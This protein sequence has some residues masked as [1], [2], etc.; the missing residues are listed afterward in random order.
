M[1]DAKVDS[2][3]QILTKWEFRKVNETLRIYIWCL[4]CQRLNKEMSLHV[5]SFQTFF[6]LSNSSQTSLG[7]KMTIDS[8]DV[9]T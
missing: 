8:N 7:I 4:E 1:N 3:Y 9:S 5:S 6:N 2:E